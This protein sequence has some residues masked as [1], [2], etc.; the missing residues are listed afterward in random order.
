MR[1]TKEKRRKKRMMYIRKMGKTLTRH[2]KEMH[3]IYPLSKKK[4]KN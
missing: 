3:V 2:W 4:K 1:R